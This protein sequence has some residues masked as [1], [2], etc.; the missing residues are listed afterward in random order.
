[1]RVSTRSTAVE[2][3][4]AAT[5]RLDRAAEQTL[6]FPSDKV[7]LGKDLEPAI[8]RISA[9]LQLRANLKT[10]Q[11]VDQMTDDVLKLMTQR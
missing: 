6:A 3:I 4:Q 5:E 2:G 9:S 10:I 11:S 7:S 1:M 8:E